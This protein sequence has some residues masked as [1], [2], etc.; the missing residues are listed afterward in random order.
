[1]ALSKEDAVKRARADL[2]QR[3]GVSENDIKEDAVESADFPDMAL[4]APIEDEMS[5]QMI[6]S[7]WRIRLKS[8]GQSYEYRANRDQLRLYNYKGANYRL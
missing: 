5:A 4:G 2:A 8:G 3:L 1:M 7:G 6:A